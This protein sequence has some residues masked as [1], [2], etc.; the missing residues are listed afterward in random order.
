LPPPPP[1][2]DPTSDGLFEAASRALGHRHAGSP[3]NFCPL[4]DFELAS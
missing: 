1:I 4:T 2:F 3:T